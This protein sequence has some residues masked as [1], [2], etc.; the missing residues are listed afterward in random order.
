MS[1]VVGER[2]VSDSILSNPTDML[3]NIRNVVKS[4]DF[5]NYQAINANKY[6]FT[7]S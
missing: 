2:G 4:G 5:D 3:G 1:Q 7:S 6:D